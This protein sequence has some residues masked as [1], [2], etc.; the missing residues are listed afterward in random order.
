MALAESMDRAQLAQQDVERG[1]ARFEK[2]KSPAVEKI[3]NTRTLLQRVRDGARSGMDFVRGIG[4]RIA[5]AS[6]RT[7]GATERIGSDVVTGI[8]TGAS[9]AAEGIANGARSGAERLANSASS[10]YESFTDTVGR[11]YDATVTGIQNASHSLSDRYNRMR[12]NMDFASGIRTLQDQINRLENDATNQRRQDAADL[13]AASGNQEQYNAVMDRIRE[14][15]ASR[16]ENLERL[17]GNLSSERQ[18][19]VTRQG[20]LRARKTAAESAQ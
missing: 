5:E 8:A 20:E 18:A 2:I 19:L 11:G 3:Q 4:N 12:V 15:E 9:N 16:G 7:L 1:R 10:A 13:R 17:V 6:F 14:A